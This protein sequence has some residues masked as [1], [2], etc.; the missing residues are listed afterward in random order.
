MISV[1]AYSHAGHQRRSLPKV[2][3]ASLALLQVGSEQGLSERALDGVEESRL[4]LRLN[5][6]DAAEGQPEQTIVVG[7]G[8]ELG[9]DRSGSLNS[10]RG[11]GN[12]TDDDLVG[13]DSTSGTRSVTV[14]DVPAVALLEGT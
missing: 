10:L 14:R 6:V 3:A 2:V 7:V 5:G 4:S 9:R 8:S 12:A 1:R 13:V 11:G